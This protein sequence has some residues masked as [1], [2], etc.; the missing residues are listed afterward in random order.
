MNPAA[1]VSSRRP[2]APP[3]IRPPQ[4]RANG[5]DQFDQVWENLAHAIRVIC[6]HNAGCLSFEELYRN[7][8]N[9][10]LHKHGR[11]LYEGVKTVV[12]EHL[13]NVARDKIV[14]AFPQT[15]P[16]G[17]MTGATEYL[18]L[19]GNMFDDH[20]TCLGM[21]RDIL[22]Y[23]N[24]VYVPSNNLLPVYDLGLD[25]FRDVVA[26]STTYPIGKHLVDALLYQ[27]RLERDG[28]IIDRLV[29]KHVIDMLSAL[30]ATTVLP[31]LGT[32]ATVYDVD[33][34]TKFLETSAAFYQMEGQTYIRECDATEY[35]K[36]AAKR[37]AEEEARTSNYLVPTT[38][39]KIRHVVEE[40]LLEHHVK[41]VI[42][43]ENSGMV[44]MMSNEKIDDLGRMYKLF[45]RV[46]NGHNEMR[47][48]LSA[49]IEELVRGV[50]E[51]AGG[52]PVADTA[53][54]EQPASRP[55]SAS[56]I[57][58]SSPILWVE[59]ILRIKGKLEVILKRA[60]DSD[61][62]FE[63][64]IND[65]LQRSINKN[66]RAP[67]FVSLFI[68]ENLKKGLKG[69]TEEEIDSLLDKTVTLF[70]FVEEKDIFER[71][72]KQHLAKRLLFGKSVSEDAEKSM[73]GKLK[74][75]CGYQFTAK[76][77]G[78]FN[79]MRM[80][81]DLMSEYRTYLTK[82]LTVPKNITEL[83]ISILT[84]TF[85]PMN[86]I[87]AGEA[88]LFPPEITA[89]LEHF[90]KF[91]HMKH[92]GRRLTWSPQFGSADLRATFDKGKKEIN[93]STY[94]MIV[95]V[96]AF[97]ACE[98][99]EEVELSRIANLTGIP[100]ADL[101]RTLQSLALGKHKIL[102]KSTKGKDIFPGD[103]FR[104]NT[105][106]TS[107]LHKI[108]IQQVSAAAANG[109]GGGGGSLENDAERTSTMEKIDET[110]KHQIEAC[111]VR[112]MKSRKRMDH[113]NLVAEVIAQTSARFTPS[114]V[115]VKKRIESL[116][117]R[118]YLER[119]KADRKRYNYLA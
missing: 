109:N 73:I 99:G 14:P 26:R 116:I 86:S 100:D 34:E 3:K 65:A 9:M 25:I 76:W 101:K 57:Q 114:P 29:V 27:I 67:E 89:S 17:G 23:M 119:D 74:V 117:E 8:Y 48:T 54:P 40:Q 63:T 11:K 19:L 118:E 97:N 21:I 10:V 112:I 49:Y 83:S 43:M 6:C 64:T 88:C 77:E 44:P 1:A 39:G 111:V 92:S 66:K 103:K 102:L 91:Y 37:L 84:T 13:S 46:S 58:Q 38:E 75:E 62:T 16:G 12:S 45:G 106:F 30:T 107:P 95:L 82:S 60:M 79:D 31:R 115:L 87:G 18:R 2:K 33:F 47:E 36:K 22:L 51:T 93:V 24:K 98:A 52:V 81:S 32:E 56:A 105:A 80:S 69:K 35:L 42:D 113:N 53:G 61:R 108:K 68:D 90:S 41:T 5:E 4:R 70:R 104:V 85:W 71:Y 7:G 28:E 50:N 59:E 15:A 94:G 96:G 55:L 20:S 110:R 78:M 72:Y